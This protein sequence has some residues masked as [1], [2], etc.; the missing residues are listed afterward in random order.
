MVSAKSATFLFCFVRD[1]T[2]CLAELILSSLR[3]DAKM[4]GTRLTLKTEKSCDLSL[5]VLFGAK[6]LLLRQ[7]FVILSLE[8]FDRHDFVSFKCIAHEFVSVQ[9]VTAHKS[10]TIKAVMNIA[11]SLL[12]VAT[13]NVCSIATLSNGKE[14]QQ[15]IMEETG[16][17]TVEAIS[18]W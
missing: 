11:A 1:S 18:L 12:T 7:G 17:Q 13:S 2:S 10:C 3:D 4:A 6:W 5:V 8:V 14:I 9:T 15:T 16:G